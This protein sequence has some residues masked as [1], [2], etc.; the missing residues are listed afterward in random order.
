M[1]IYEVGGT[2]RDDLMGRKPRDIDYAVEIGSF[3]ELQ[4]TLKDMGFTF[5]AVRPEFLTIR[6]LA[7]KD[8]KTK[9]L[10]IKNSV[11]DFVMC[12]KDGPSADGRRPDFVEPGTILDDL[13]RRDFTINAIARDVDTGE[14][15]DP[16]GGEDDIKNRRLR[17]VGDPA[18]R[19]SEDGLRVIRAL[20]FYI[21][22]DL[23]VDPTTLKLILSPFASHMLASVSIERIREELEKM[24]GYNTIASLHLLGTAPMFFR[25]AVFRDGLKLFPSLRK[26]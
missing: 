21:T 4:T 10:N 11:V 5:Y 12:R 9:Q 22:L 7:P 19:I 23:I 6:A 15:I 14:L 16:Y 25:D 13:A 1:K 18:T 2:V 8:S 24:F 26:T 17:F 20:R 3:D